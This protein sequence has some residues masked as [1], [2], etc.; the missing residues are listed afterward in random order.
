MSPLPQ[1]IFPPEHPTSTQA[2]TVETSKCRRE[3]R[4]LRSAATSAEQVCF[5]FAAQIARLSRHIQGHK[6]EEVCLITSLDVTELPAA[7]WLQLNRQAW[8]IESGL[9]QRLDVSHNDDRSRVRHPN[10]M[11]V[12][13]L[14]RR[15]ANSL[16][17]EWRAQFPKPHHK[18]TT[19]F[20]AYLSQEHC[21]RGIRFLT[22]KRPHLKHPS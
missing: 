2:R 18:T 6:P 4:S 16:F 15:L 7:R 9:H 11:L 1:R 21:R 13:A 17:M 22:A 12:F 14:M 19:D 10:V 8:G 3:E 5:P 20:Q